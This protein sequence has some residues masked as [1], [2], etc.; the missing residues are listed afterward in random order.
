MDYTIYTESESEGIQKHD[1]SVKDINSFRS[2]L[3]RFIVNYNHSKHMYEEDIISSVFFSPK[4]YKELL[5]IRENTKAGNPLLDSIIRDLQ[6]EDVVL[7]ELT[8]E[9]LQKYEVECKKVKIGFFPYNK[10]GF[11][12]EISG[13]ISQEEK[14]KE[15]IERECFL[16]R[17]ED[18]EKLEIKLK[19]LLKR[20]IVLFRE[21]SKTFGNLEVKELLNLYAFNLEMKLFPLYG[22]DS[23]FEVKV[24]L[25]AIESSLF[26]G[27]NEPIK[28]EI[29]LTYH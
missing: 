19:D 2:C 16:G 28:E 22:E 18:K 25:R 3:L 11:C 6:G 21:Y 1:L 12:N 4:L 15:K 8:Q 27:G 26:S 17:E 7:M 23:C 14:I 5:I 9:I 29:R 20:K 13:C 24:E 10:E